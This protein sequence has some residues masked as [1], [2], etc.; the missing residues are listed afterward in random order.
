MP[1]ILQRSIVLHAHQQMD[2]DAFIGLISYFQ[3]RF[4]NFALYGIFNYLCQEL[5]SGHSAVALASLRQLIMSDTALTRDFNL[6]PIL[7]SLESLLEFK[8]Q[9]AAF[10]AQDD[11]STQLAQDM[12]ELMQYIHSNNN[13]KLTEDHSVLFLET[14]TTGVTPSTLFEKA[15]LMFKY[16]V[17][18]G[19]SMFMSDVDAD[20][21]SLWDDQPA[22]KMQ[23][24]S[25]Y[26]D[27][28]LFETALEIGGGHWFV[29]MIVDQV[30]EAGRSGGAVRAGKVY[31]C[32]CWCS[33]IDPVLQLNSAPVSSRHRSSIRQTHTT[34]AS[35][36]C[37]ACCRMCC[38]PA[39]RRV[40]SK[41]CRSFRAKPWASLQ[42][43]VLC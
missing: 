21:N 3:K 26:L 34:A 38:H 1:T 39:L 14:V 33:C 28:V 9:E 17:K 8:R 19:R 32:V 25:H 16:I 20:T 4:L 36:S 18:S 27:M 41:T 31:L 22:S 29:G 43:T 30:L 12:S 11:E 5:L 42:A 2:Q 37:A 40:Q 15:E 23:M 24:V 35:I 10:A 13:N 7:G 6:H